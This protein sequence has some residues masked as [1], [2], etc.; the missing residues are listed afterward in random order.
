MKQIFEIPQARPYLGTCYS[1]FT[2]W[3]HYI[4]VLEEKRQLQKSIFG[5]VKIVIFFPFFLPTIIKT[6]F[7]ASHT[8]QVYCFRTAVKWVTLHIWIKYEKFVKWQVF[9]PIRNKEFYSHDNNY[10]SRL[11]PS[12]KPVLTRKFSLSRTFHSLFIS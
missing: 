11:E 2:T 9:D 10:S 8:L 6:C 3:L 7:I 1:L 4:H 12:I 5:H